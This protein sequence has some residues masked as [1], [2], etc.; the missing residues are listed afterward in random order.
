MTDLLRNLG[1]SVA[2]VVVAL[3]VAEAC[4]RAVD[5]R[6][7]PSANAVPAWVDDRQLRRE[8]HWIELLAKNDA[9][10][11]YFE[12]YQWDRFLFY[13]VRPGLQLELLDYAA[14]PRGRSRTA[15]TVDTN[16]L[17]F[18]DAMAQEEALVRFFTD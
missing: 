16:E 10:A 2:A 5:L 3:G 4:A 1:L 17:G 8:A 12:L 9:V 7:A 13:R 15:W 14:P 11:R 18:R 6:P